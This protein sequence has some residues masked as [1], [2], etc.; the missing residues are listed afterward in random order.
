MG[1]LT[2]EALVRFDD[3]R[4]RDVHEGGALEKGESWI[5]ER[6]GD[7]AELGGEGGR[8]GGKGGESLEED[9]SG[10]V[11]GVEEVTGVTERG[12]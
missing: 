3:V 5:D 1:L 9:V 4:A 6:A 10:A 7:S 12:D 8:E 11:T 2:D